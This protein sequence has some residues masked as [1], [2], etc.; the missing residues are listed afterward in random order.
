MDDSFH[1]GYGSQIHNFFSKFGSA[2][3][4][5]SASITVILFF[6]SII[7]LINWL[8]VSVILGDPFPRTIFSIIR[9]QRVKFEIPLNCSYEGLPGTCPSNYPLTIELDESSSA[10]ACPEYFRWIHQDLKPW[11]S[12]G[13]TREMVERGRAHAHF[14]LVIVNG[15]AYVENYIK[16]FQTRD[17]F[18]IWGILQLL[19]LYPGMVPDLEL[20]F[21]CEDRPVVRK[22][23]YQGPNATAPPPVFHY[24][25]NKNALDIVFP[26]WTFWGWAET[27]IRPWMQTLMAIKE[28]NKRMNWIDRIPYAFWKGNPKV[29]PAREELMNCNISDEF[30][31]KARLY[32]LDW[33]KIKKGGYN[34]TRLE[35][36]CTHR[37]KIYVEGIAWSVS[38]KYIMACDSMTLLVKPNY[39]D[40][41]IR[42]M[43]PMQHYW[44]INNN[45]KCRDLKFA[46]EWGNN[47]TDVALA[48]GKAGSEFIHEN[49]TMKYVYDYMFH[50][51]SEYA[52]LLKFKPEVPPGATEVC[53]EMKACSEKGRWKK[54]MVQSLVKSPSDKLPCRLPPPYEP[55]E[56]KAFLD[57]K[58]NISKKVQ[59]WESQYWESL[60]KKQ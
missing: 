3:V 20:M 17:M 56:L 52:K 25:G 32:T 40:F 54:F 29:A 16:P 42:S 23:L 14:R 60:N 11:K 30:D 26:D 55:P 27:N 47:H 35:D 48:I 37:Y 6:S 58:K 4:K 46:V 51:L 8:D 44:P 57:R 1:V 28:G 13:I 5:R 38:E 10:A 12:T 53:S 36:Q 15:K 45:N 59:K 19:R 34:D 31:W 9:K 50:L 49:L 43:V 22:R 21:W 39:H 2:P 24:C 41:F 33:S 7:V 18:T